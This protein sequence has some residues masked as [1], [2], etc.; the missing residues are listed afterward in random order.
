MEKVGTKALSET[1]V[2]RKRFQEIVRYALEVNTQTDR[3]FSQRDL[4]DK[5]KVAPT[6]IT[7]YL[8]GRV[9]F[10]SMK[11]VTLDFLAK[12]CGLDVGTLYAWIEKG[13]DEAIRHQ[14]RVEQEPAIARP[15][16]LLRRAL[17]ML[18]NEKKPP[19][20]KGPRYPALRKAI[21]DLRLSVGEAVYPRLIR[22]AEAEAALQAVEAGEDLWLDAEDALAALL[23]LNV[24]E[25]RELASRPA[26]ADGDS[27]RAVDAQGLAIS[28]GND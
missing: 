16:D 21:R 4:A 22:L 23:E 17:S 5:L 11:A 6:M 27:I 18:E 8:Q 28:V 12:S 7:R 19:G 14:E 9:E 2:R 3:R 20:Q 10:W 24:D 15:Q 26:E 25:V 1:E 13:R